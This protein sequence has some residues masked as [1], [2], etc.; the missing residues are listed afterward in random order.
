MRDGRESEGVMR[1]EDETGDVV[2][3]IGDDRLGEDVGQ[4]QPLCQLS[5]DTPVALSA[6]M[7]AS[8]SPE[9]GGVARLGRVRRSGKT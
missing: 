4:R 6:A 9:R 1:V 3:L 5:R 7:P 8:M 2:V